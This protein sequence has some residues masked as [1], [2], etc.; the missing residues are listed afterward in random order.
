M[1]KGAILFIFCFALSVAIA[2]TGE[3]RTVNSA[4]QVTNL[5]DVISQIEY[6]K[7]LRDNFVE[8]SVVVVVKICEKG[9]LKDYRIRKSSDPLFQASV[10]NALDDLQFQ[11]ATNTSGEYVESRI[12]IPFEFK[13]NFD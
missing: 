1:K 3:K 2:G 5:N 12:S 6:P 8:G 4:P 7:T 11:P 10:E 9:N 13:L